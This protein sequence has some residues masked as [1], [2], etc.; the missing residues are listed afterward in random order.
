[1]HLIVVTV[2]P[3]VSPTAIL[4]SQILVHKAQDR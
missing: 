3:V 2:Q 4:K 1:V